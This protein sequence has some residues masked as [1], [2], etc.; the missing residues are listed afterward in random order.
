M[1]SFNPDADAAWRSILPHL[2]D[3]MRSLKATEQNA[4]VLRYF[5][6][7]SWREVG[8]ALSLNEDTAQKQASRALDK[9]RIHFR[10]HGVV[11]SAAAIATV[12]SAN[13]AQAAPAGLAA[14]VASASL[15]SAGSFSL[16]TYI[17][18]LIMKK[19]AGCSI[20]GGIGIRRHHPGHRLP[21]QEIAILKYIRPWTD[22]GGKRPAGTGSRL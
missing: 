13:A 4:I 3:A 14:T 19:T 8:T 12:I 15:A 16:S 22:L 7:R 20:V 10:R 17:H 9:L 1:S 21:G 5:E 6:G 18:A 2:D 11:L